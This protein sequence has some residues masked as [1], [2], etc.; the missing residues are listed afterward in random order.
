CS[1]RPG[2][3]SQPSHRCW[4]PHRAGPQCCGYLRHLPT[5]PVRPSADASGEGDVRST[6]DRHRTVTMRRTRTVEFLAD[7]DG[8]LKRVVRLSDGKEYTH[9]C[10][11]EVYEAVAMVFEDGQGHTLE[12]IVGKLDAPFTQVNCRVRRV[13]ASV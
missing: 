2:R 1:L 5:E 8:A 13:I 12:E 4:T 11:Q 10:T 6:R 3:Q 9:R 7:D